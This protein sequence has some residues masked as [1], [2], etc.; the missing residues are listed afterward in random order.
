MDTPWRL[1]AVLIALTACAE[2]DRPSGA[3]RPG[4]GGVGA[5]A[6]D[7]GT[8]VGSDAG[9]AGVAN[10][11][12][13]AAGQGYNALPIDCLSLERSQVVAGDDLV[14]ELRATDTPSGLAP[15]C[16][17]TGCCA[18]VV[19]EGEDAPGLFRQSGAVNGHV[20][21]SDGTHYRVE[22]FPINPYAPAGVFAVKALRLDD[23][24]GSRIELSVDPE[25]PSHYQIVSEVY[26]GGEPIPTNIGVLSVEVLQPNVTDLTP[27]EVLDLR[28]ERRSHAPGDDLV[29]IALLTDDVSGVKEGCC[30]S[31]GLDVNTQVVFA[32]SD[33]VN[34]QVVHESG[35]RYRL[36]SFPIRESAPAGTYQI[37][38]LGI[39][40]EAGNRRRLQAGAETYLYE[41]GT[42]TGIPVLEFEITVP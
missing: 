25:D 35:Q 38:A 14:F 9:D 8:A 17:K 18:A 3:R 36:E 21:Q 37:T 5:D 26:Q 20:V 11:G 16:C 19:L 6:G 41:D 24:D 23:V 31:V 40:D 10:G 32:N 42:D 39:G 34:G 30:A 1:V 13:C 4:D 29:I 28:L 22:Q 2:Q 7:A 27:V 15:Q 12:G 33:S